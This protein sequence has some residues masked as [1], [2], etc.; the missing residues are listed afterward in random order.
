MSLCIGSRANA[1]YE[2]I[3]SCDVPM[4]IYINMYTHVYY[5]FLLNFTYQHSDGHTPICQTAALVFPCRHYT[6]IYAF[7]PVITFETFACVMLHNKNERPDC[8]FNFQSIPYILLWNVRCLLVLPSYWLLMNW[9]VFS[10][11]NICLYASSHFHLYHTHPSF[12]IRSP[13][14]LRLM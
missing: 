5:L 3:A 1:N 14:S 2:R 7:V 13:Y 4:Y 6:V 10:T 12:F 8:W 11:F 9:H